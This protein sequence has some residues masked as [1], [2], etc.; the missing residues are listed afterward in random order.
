MNWSLVPQQIATGILN[1]GIIAL[2]A[3]G[4]VLIFKSSEVFNFAQGHL[5]ML[6]AFLTWWFAGANEDGGELFNLPLWAAILMA[7]VASVLIGLLIERLALRPMTGQP[8][9]SIVLMTLGLSQLIEGL[10]SIIFGNQPKSNFPTPF[11]PAEVLIIP[12]PGAFGDAI[13]LKYTLVAAFVVAMAA[14]L[15]FILFFRL[16]KTGLAMRATAENHELART[17]GIKVPRIFGL[18]WAIAGVVATLGGVL[19]ATL[20][21]AS[22]NL[23]T[24]VLVAFPAILLGGLDSFPGA[25]L[26]GIAVG[27]A[28]E[29]VLASSLAE[30]R[31]SAEIAPYVL[32]LIVLILRPEGLFGQKRIERI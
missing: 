30:V 8:L 3:L 20:T 31:N 14:A 12:F 23:A 4:V 6:G 2:I 18:S 7:V 9:L 21:G 26:G 17:M 10:A 22:L 25:I 29:F 5:V 24:V 15:S 32:L 19:L 28:K 13:R 11:S 27:V 16:T 1:G